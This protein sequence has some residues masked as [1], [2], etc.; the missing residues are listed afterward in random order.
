MVG[1]VQP[2][3]T[4]DQSANWRAETWLHVPNKFGVGVSHWVLPLRRHDRLVSVSDPSP[5]D[6]NDPFLPSGEAA[7]TRHNIY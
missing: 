7:Q 1:A 4:A 5:Y 2:V 6:A 3:C